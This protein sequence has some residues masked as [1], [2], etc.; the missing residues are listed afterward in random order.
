MLRPCAG[1][2]PSS[3]ARLEL[4]PRN[5]RR[6]PAC[7][8]HGKRRG[9]RPLARPAPCGGANR[10]GTARRQAWQTRGSALAPRPPC[11]PAPPTTPRTFFDCPCTNTRACRGS[12]H[13]RKSKWEV[14]AFRKSIGRERADPGDVA[15]HLHV[16]AEEVEIA[17]E[18][19]FAHQVDNHVGMPHRLRTKPT[20]WSEG[21]AARQ[22]TQG[23][24]GPQSCSWDRGD[25][26]SQV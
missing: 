25:E 19:L 7:M 13:S 2:P 5:G 14:D 22:R 9:G 8:T 12:R 24:A 10:R 15:D 26:S 17:S 23:V 16:C 18:L 4:H 6:R 3:A 21:S 20:Y 11:T 1:S